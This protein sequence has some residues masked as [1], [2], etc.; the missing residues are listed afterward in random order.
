[1]ELLAGYM[2]KGLNDSHLERISSIARETHV[3]AGD[4]I[5]REGE[6]AKAIYYRDF[7]LRIDGDRFRD[8]IRSFIKKRK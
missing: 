4:E 1:M 6:D 7:W 2:F 5:Y 8:V 3:G